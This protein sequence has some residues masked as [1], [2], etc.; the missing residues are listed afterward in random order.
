MRHRTRVDFE[1]SGQLS[2][3]SAGKSQDFGALAVSDPTL[4]LEMQNAACGIGRFKVGR[5]DAGANEITR[6]EK[7]A[8]GQQRE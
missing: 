5:L 7:P 1:R 4:E 2:R 6:C 8:G 3:T